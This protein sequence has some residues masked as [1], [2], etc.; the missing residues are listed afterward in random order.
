[1]TR[2]QIG[3]RGG[4]HMWFGFEKW[5]PHETAM[6]PRL[7]VADI[8]MTHH[9]QGG[10]RVKAV[11][12]VSPGRIHNYRRPFCLKT[13]YGRQENIVSVLLS[14]EFHVIALYNK[15]NSEL[16]NR[17]GQYS[18]ITVFQRHSMTPTNKSSLEFFPQDTT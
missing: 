11:Y 16:P 9:C 12:R 15:D 8:Y 5:F 7:A 14:A 3:A 13:N 2:A 10:M 17:G 6:E 1:M 18:N 4:V